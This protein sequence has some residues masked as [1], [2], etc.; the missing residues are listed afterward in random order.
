MKQALLRTTFAVLVA[1]Q[2]LPQT[3]LYAAGFPQDYGRSGGTAAGRTDEALA[4]L[5]GRVPGEVELLLSYSITLGRTV[6]EEDSNPFGHVA[7][8][9]GDRV[10][11]ANQG[12]VVGEDAS[13]FVAAPLKDYLFGVTPPTKHSLSGS[14]FGVQYARTTIGLRIRGLAR[15][16]LSAMQI[17][18]RQLDDAWRAGKLQFDWKRNNCAHVTRAI[19]AAGGIELLRAKEINMPL[20]VF[21]GIRKTLAARRGVTLEYVGYQRVPGSRNDY[22]H[23]QYPMSLSRPVRSLGQLMGLRSGYRARERQVHHWIVGSTSVPFVAYATQPLPLKEVSPV[24]TNHPIEAGVR[25]LLDWI[26]G[27]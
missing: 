11:T 2:F 9:I 23:Q 15:D 27:R 3:S 10:Y 24:V 16:R 4:Q 13:M 21:D 26:R 22:Q 8:R 5:N 20:E 6:F 14:N 17:R 25:G 18:I 7:I 1:T 19:A 12:A